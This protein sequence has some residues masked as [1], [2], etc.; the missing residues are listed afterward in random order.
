MKKMYTVYIND[1]PLSFMPFEDSLNGAELVF[2]LTGNEEPEKLQFMIRAFEQNVL[3]SNMFFQSA[4]I[5]KTWRTFNGLYHIIEAAGGIVVNEENCL[6]MIFRN[7]KWDLPKGKIEKGEEHDAAAIREVTEECGV[8][9]MQLQKQLTTTYHTYTLNG[10]EILKKTFWFLMKSSDYSKL[11]P[12]VEEGITDVRW[13]TKADVR[14]VI[15][16]T[17]AS[18]TMLIKEQV[19]D[20]SPSL[21]G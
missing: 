10:Q 4:N 19:L 5:D 18:I 20:D 11:V 8:G 13:M 17:Y 1:R 9:Q 6:L 2:K 16:Q 14:E 12:Q 15:P 7:G 3:V 21:L